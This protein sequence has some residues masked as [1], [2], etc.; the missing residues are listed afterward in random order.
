MAT[1]TAAIATTW[2]DDGGDGDNDGGDGDNMARQRLTAM[3]TTTLQAMTARA[4]K[5]NEQVRNEWEGKQVQ[6]EWEGKQDSTPMRIQS[7]D[8]GL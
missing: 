2:H 4:P 6:N 1:T 3:A 5:L 7:D 8:N